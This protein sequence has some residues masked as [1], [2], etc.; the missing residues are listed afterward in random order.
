MNHRPFEIH[1]PHR[2]PAKLG[3]P[4]QWYLRYLAPERNA[5]GTPVLDQNGNPKLK[6]YRPFY[7]SK[8]KAAA[9][10][11]RLLAQFGEAGHGAFI[12]SRAAAEE[13]EKAKQIAPEISLVD[14]AKF[15]RLHHPLRDTKLV[16]EL[17]PLF[18][19]DVERRVGKTRHWSDLK[20]RLNGR[21]S[22][23]F[24]KRI[25]ET[26]T[27]QDVMDYLKEF[28]GAGRTVLN[29]KRAICNFLGHLLQEGLV[30]Q[31]AAGGIKKRLLPKADAKEIR[32]LSLDHVTRYLRALERYDPEMVAHEI[33][34]LLS[35]VRSD[36]EMASF[37]GAWVHIETQEVVIPAD[38]AKTG[39]REVIN[40]LEESFWKWWAVYGRTGLLRPKNYE[41][42]WNRIR[43][44]AATSDT[45]TADRLAR[46]PIKV[47]LKEASSRQ[48]LSTWPWN[49]R[50]RTFCT[51]HVA[52][53]QS[54]DKTALILRHR[55]NTYTLHASYRGLGVTQDMGKRYFE[56]LPEPV[57][58]PIAPEYQPRG[59]IIKQSKAAHGDQSSP[60]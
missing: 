24:A 58:K 30:S 42:R 22:A 3:Q 1:G 13:Y 48:A 25:P 8:A 40:E 54:A 51:Y 26:I 15:W 20:S 2:D 60:S 57:K 4:K 19:A 35:G 59:I 23:R 16:G 28:K 50:R 11:P 55:G 14:A 46:L 29:E 53:H 33:V 44:L 32:F 45:E 21:F 31:N 7:E 41:P 12:Q 17:V 5:D 56:I 43:V 10:I 47:L 27:R 18:L 34:Q 38:V 9:D 49:G 36:D 52:K 37:D 39:K 6:R